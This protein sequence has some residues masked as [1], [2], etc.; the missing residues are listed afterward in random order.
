VAVDPWNMIG[1]SD[2]DPNTCRNLVNKIKKAYMFQTSR[3][4]EQIRLFLLVKEKCHVTKDR[5]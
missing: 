5:A 4:R 3:V 1:S 2:R